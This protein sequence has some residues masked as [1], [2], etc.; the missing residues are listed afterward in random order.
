M[1]EDT[2]K[3]IAMGWKELSD[4]WEYNFYVA[5]NAS[6]VFIFLNILVL[7]ELWYLILRQK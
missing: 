7:I 3:N 4:K 5:R 6:F 1:N 2:W